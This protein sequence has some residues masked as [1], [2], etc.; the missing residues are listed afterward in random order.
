MIRHGEITD[1]VLHR[2]IKAKEICF[3]GN[4]NLRIYGR[5]NCRSG[6]RMNRKNRVFFRTINEAVKLG[7]RPCGHCMNSEYKKWK[8]GS[9]Q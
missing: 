3:G 6:K 4:E 2:L 7:F 5:L 8:N 1:D 9:F